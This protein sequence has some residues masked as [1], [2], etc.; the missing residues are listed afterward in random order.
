[1]AL[2]GSKRQ[3]PAVRR[4]KRRAKPEPK[5]L[6]H[7]WPV[8][9]V[10]ETTSIYGEGSENFAHRHRITLRNKGG[11]AENMYDYGA[12]EYLAG[13]ISEMIGPK[14]WTPLRLGIIPT[15]SIVSIILHEDDKP[16]LAAVKPAT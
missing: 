2:R 12:R 3:A 16:P 9:T 4:R 7:I 1:M 13:D 5:N 11:I 15:E 10:V 8:G 14:K 6:D